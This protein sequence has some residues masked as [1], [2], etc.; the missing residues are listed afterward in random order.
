M[1]AKTNFSYDPREQPPPPQPL[2]PAAPA[3][4]ELPKPVSCYD[5]H[6]HVSI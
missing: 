5:E 4:A 2:P 1:K 3:P 6:F